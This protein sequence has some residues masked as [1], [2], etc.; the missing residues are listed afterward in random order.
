MILLT[1]RSVCSHLGLFSPLHSSFPEFSSF[2]LF[3]LFYK[4]DCYWIDCGY[5]LATVCDVSSGMHHVINL[6]RPS[7]RPAFCSA[8]D[9]NWHG[10]EVASFPGRSH[11]QYLIAY[12]MQIRRGKAWEISSRAI[13]SGRP[14]PGFP[15][16][17]DA[18][19][20]L[21]RKLGGEFRCS[22]LR[23]RTR[24]RR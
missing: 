3:S 8:S 14:F 9:K 4:S 16:H 7:P 22:Q 18:F 11:L 2:F 23:S 20:R 15:P 19:G 21:P 6:S 1:S 24:Q 5:T 12:S 13:T 10:N 17:G